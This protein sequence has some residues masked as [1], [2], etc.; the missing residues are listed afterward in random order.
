MKKQPIKP[1]WRQVLNSVSDAMIEHAQGETATW[2]DEVWALWDKERTSLLQRYS[3]ITPWEAGW[4]A[5]SR[6][7]FFAT[8]PDASAD[9]AKIPADVLEQIRIFEK[10]FAVAEQAA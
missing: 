3:D 8:R 2:T 10:T 7:R 5:W 9:W 4:I 1:I 6:L